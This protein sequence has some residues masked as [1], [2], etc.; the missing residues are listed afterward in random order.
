M[1]S[2]LGLSQIITEATRIL[3]SS[4]SCID[5]IFITQPNL[6]AESGVQPSLHP[7]CHNQIVFAKFNLQ[8]YYPPPYLREIWHYKQANTELI[9]QAITD[10]NWDRAFLNTNVNEKL[11]IFSNTILNI[12]SNFIPH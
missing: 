3:E 4:S 1:T 10:F 8:I 2:Q 12:L 5:L 7:N 6:V 11:S 9:R